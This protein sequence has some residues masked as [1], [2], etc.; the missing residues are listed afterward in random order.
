MVRTSQQERDMLSAGEPLN[1]AGTLKK[2]EWMGRESVQF[3]V[4][5]IF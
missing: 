4:E 2:K 3:I 5:E 1:I